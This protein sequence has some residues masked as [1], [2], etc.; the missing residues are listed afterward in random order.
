MKLN[1]NYQ[2]IIFEII[3]VS[4]LAVVFLF[5]FILAS[6][7]NKKLE[8]NKSA[9]VLSNPVLVTGVISGDT[10][11]IEEGKIIKLLGIEADKE[12]EGPC[13]LPAKKR[14]EELILGKRVRLKR[15]RTNENNCGQYLRYVFLG[16]KNI[17]YEL[18]REGLVRAAEH[19]SDTFY[20]EQIINAEKYATDNKIG[21]LWAKGK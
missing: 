16:E 3:A 21:C 9:S 14:L 12:G 5:M 19:S 15:G 2:K 4:F 11:I 7:S 17:S 10:I 13:F 8:Q 1:L 18:A 20:G 6:V